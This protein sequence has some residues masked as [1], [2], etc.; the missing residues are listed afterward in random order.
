MS[1]NIDGFTLV[2][3]SIVLV[4]IGL[5]VAG[6]MGGRELVENSRTNKIIA[7]VKGYKST[8]HSFVLKFNV[9]PGDMPNPRVYWPSWVSV[10]FNDGRG[11]GNGIIDFENESRMFFKH[12]SLSGMIPGNY[13]ATGCGGQPGVCVPKGPLKGSAFTARR[14]NSTTSIAQAHIHFAGYDSSV[15]GSHNFGA[16]NGQRAYAI[17]KKIDDGAPRY[18]KVLSNVGVYTPGYTEACRH[19]YPLA[20]EVKDCNL[21]FLYIE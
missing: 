4:I 13:H 12:L 20:T 5:I 21:N 9:L 7:Q 1:K 10:A 2:E 19:V 11:N 15:P 6:V 18:G 14:I 3:M 16:L 8:I 17:D